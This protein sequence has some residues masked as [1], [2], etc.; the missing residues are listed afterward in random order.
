MSKVV[1]IL[2]ATTAGL[3]LTSLHLVKQVRD[4]DAAIAELKT[5]VTSLQEQVAAA[6]KFTPL[7][8]PPAIAGV[9]A[10]PGSVSMP[11]AREPKE[12]KEAKNLKEPALKSAAAQPLMSAGVALMSPNPPSREERMQMMREHRERQRQLMQDPEYREAM[13]MQSRSQLARQ[14]PGVIQELGLDQQQAEDFFNMLAD[15]QMRSTELMEP[16]WDAENSENRD[17]TA[18]QERHGKIQQV[19]SE[20]QRNNEAEMASRFGPAKVQA[21]KEYQSTVGHRYQLEQMR[22]TFSAQGVPLSDDVSKPMLKALAAAQKA[23]MDEFSSAV[24]RGAAPRLA[25]RA[26]ANL[27]I[28]GG[29][30]MEQQIEMT[31]KRNQRMLDAVSPYLSFEQRQALEREHDSQLKMMEAQARVMR[32]R[33]TSDA[34]GVYTD[35][36]ANFLIL[37]K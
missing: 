31:K 33:G 16:L 29:N 18:F 23:E 9:F 4:G 3:G 24:S 21:W 22:N 11:P 14:Y 12:S 19:A 36:G 17:P 32:A 34:N 28:E 7:P 13:R 26:T 5:Q 1:L 37:Q 30:N 8:P 20:M 25:A 15:Q 35:G 2:V 6:P 10:S 27:A